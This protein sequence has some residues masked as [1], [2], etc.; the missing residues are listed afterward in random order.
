MAHECISCGGECF[1]SGDIDDCIVSK[2]PTTCKTCDECQDE[3]NDDS[4]DDY[5][6]EEDD[7]FSD[8]P[9]YYLC[10]SCG[11]TC[12]QNHGLSGCPKCTAIMSPENY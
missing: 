11:Y 7:E 3:L 6:E 9:D 10:F 8:E 4:D 2:T 5:D 12:V 1:C